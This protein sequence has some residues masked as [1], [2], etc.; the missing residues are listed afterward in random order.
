MAE[1]GVLLTGREL[2]VLSLIA[3]GHPAQE[4]A[5]VLRIAL[6]SVENHKRHIYRKL[7]VGNQ[8]EAVARAHALGLFDV[9]G[10]GVRRPGER[11]AS[12]LSDLVVVHARARG[13]LEPVVVALVGCGRP[14]AVVARPEVGD[15]DHLLAWHRGGFLA[16]LVDPG[17]GAWRLAV[18]LRA[19]TVVVPTASP[20]RGSAMEAISHGAHAVVWL[21][22]VP[23][24]L[25]QVLATLPTGYF[26]MSSA[27]PDQGRPPAL[28]ARERD[29]LAAI[30][31]GHT[32]RQ[33]GRVLGISGKT[34]E[35][36]RARLFSKLGA[37]NRSE[38]LT[39]AYRW[40]LLT[41]RDSPDRPSRT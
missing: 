41:D 23:E 36:T 10:S 16:V 38:A 21:D 1:N 12:H 2:A 27:C 9:V 13:L 40:G 7:G 17:A 4:I 29:V 6:C 19:L 18:R 24:H 34:V 11:L 14:F 15:D 35:N 8:A 39:N 30:A 33:T 5:A 22:D 32:I 20:E 3:S 28:T 25:G 37:R 26:V 31:G